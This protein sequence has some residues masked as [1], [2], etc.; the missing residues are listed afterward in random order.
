[1]PTIQKT[2]LPKSQ[3][4]LEFEVGYEE[5]RPYLEEAARE[6]STARPLPGFRP[7]KAGFD[8]VK[9]AYGEMKIL[10]GALERIIRAF[11]AKAILNESL[12]IVG[13]PN[14][15]VDKL[16]PEQ[17]LKF[18]IT[19]PIEPK[20]TELPDLTGCVVEQTVKEI[21]DKELGEA[22]EEMRKMRRQEVRVE[23]E[24]TLEDLVVVDVSML[25]DGV[26]VE[27]GTGRDY[28]IYMNEPHYIPGFSEKLV[29]IKAGE[30]RNFTLPFPSEHYQ[31]HLAGKDI[32]FTTKATGVF[33][34]Q[35]PPLDDAFAQGVGLKDM[36]ELK[37]KLQENLRVEEKRRREEASE[38]EL[39]E[40]LV[41]TT[42]FTE[43]PE[44]L[45]TDETRRM[46]DELQHGV[47]EQGMKWED[48]L[49]SI[50]KTRDELRLDM[51]A[52]AIR[53]VKTAVLVKAFAK[54]QA[55]TVTEEELDKETDEILSRIRENDQETRERVT[56]PEYRQYIAIQLRNRKTLE[57]LKKECVK[58]KK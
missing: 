41:D 32:D 49:S 48:Y 1:M 20:V 8:E 6:M 3:V 46:M 13:S 57:W 12:D 47:E 2:D 18:T 44:A 42:K 24:A 17:P 4:K 11:Y 25:K 23:R 14:V 26:V 9:R 56:S 34:M 28:R 52:Q 16:A 39:L 10:E 54:A 43:V 45:I 33:E 29:G 36:E 30:E 55:V 40:K 22:L 51:T 5:V 21:G 35:L 50:K 27:G 53:R 15:Q 58:E 19:A 31:K 37:A 38:I 7:G